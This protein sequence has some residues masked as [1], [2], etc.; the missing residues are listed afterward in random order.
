MWE[1]EEVGVQVRG[2]LHYGPRSCPMLDGVIPWSHSHG[3]IFEIMQ[4]LKPL[5]PLTRCK[6]NVD[7]EE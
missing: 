1:I 6:P 5:G 3:E 7:Q 2:S 4:T